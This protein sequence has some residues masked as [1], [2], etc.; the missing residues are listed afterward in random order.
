[1][2]PLTTATAF[3]TIVGLLRIFRQ[4]RG[5]RER[6][7]HQ[8]FIEW[9]DYHGH[10]ELKNL[11]AN[12][13]A[14]R[15]EVDNLLQ[16]DHA[17][18]LEKLD[19]I[20]DILVNLV[21]RVHGLREIALAVAPNSTLSEQAISILR[22]FVDSGADQIRYLSEGRGSIYMEFVGGDRKPDLTEPRLVTDDLNQLVA[23]QLL[24]VEGHT[25]D[26]KTTYGITRNA[27]RYIA[28]VDGKPSS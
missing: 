18:M 28:V 25:P 10:E 15:T 1:M 6:L 7:N 2:E 27:V 9:V 16:A 5:E 8:N 3:A 14:L 13:A 12:N 26:G 21:S 4:E 20:E 23:L 24:S 17:Q 19:R 11:I 22:E